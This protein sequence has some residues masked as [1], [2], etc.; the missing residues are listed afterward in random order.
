METSTMEAN[1]SSFSGEKKVQYNF[2][3][4][5]KY[6]NGFPLLNKRIIQKRPFLNKVYTDFLQN[7]LVLD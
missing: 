6:L 7:K 1:L 3:K 4:G 2:L 5:E